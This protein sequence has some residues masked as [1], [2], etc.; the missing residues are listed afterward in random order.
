[1]QAKIQGFSGPIPLL[2]SL[3]NITKLTPDLLNESL[4]CLRENRLSATN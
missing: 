2:L 3:L 4:L 1:M